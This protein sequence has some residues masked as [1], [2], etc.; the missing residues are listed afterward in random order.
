MALLVWLSDH[1]LIYSQRLITGQV[2]LVNAGFE[3]KSESDIQT[4]FANRITLKKVLQYADN[5]ARL[6]YT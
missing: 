2:R 6:F 1:D 4:P 3:F 5:K